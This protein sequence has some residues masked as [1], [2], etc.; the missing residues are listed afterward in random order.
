MT[1][2]LVPALAPTAATNVATPV[3]RLTVHVPSPAMV[4]V[5]LQTE[6]N[7]S[8]RQGPLLLPVC[9]LVPVASAP[10]PVMR[11]EKVAVPP[12]MTAWLSGVA[13]GAVGG[14]TVG[15]MVALPTCA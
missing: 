9:R 8:T 12:G 5:A 7:G 15:V 10:P 4:N 13:T 2:V 11:F 1:G 6:S 14:L 3:L